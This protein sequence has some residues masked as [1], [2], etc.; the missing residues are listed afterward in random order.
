MPELSKRFYD[1]YIY[2]QRASVE[3]II[4]V[5]VKNGV[6]QKP[7][8][9]VLFHLVFGPI[10]MLSLS[11]EMFTTMPDLDILLPAEKLKNGHLEAT[12]LYLN[13]KT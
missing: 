10:V 2:K 4:D 13:A 12:L 5:G 9:D 6:F 11:R 8:S 1:E 7:D 3:S